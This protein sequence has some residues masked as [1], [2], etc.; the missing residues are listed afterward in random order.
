MNTLASNIFEIEYV[1]TFNFKYQKN[2]NNFR[3]TLNLIPLKCT[4][5]GNAVDKVQFGVCVGG[6]RKLRMIWRDM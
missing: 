4:I 6:S 5:S 2:E 3:I 1:F